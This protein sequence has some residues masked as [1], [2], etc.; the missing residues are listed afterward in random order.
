MGKAEQEI[1]ERL[2][3]IEGQI[4]GVR[5]MQE[6]GRYCIDVLDQISAVRAAL[7]AVALLILEGHVETCVHDAVEA[8]EGAEKGAE[9]TAAVRRLLKSA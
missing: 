7:S 1:L 9:L 5:R 2:R 6:D 4:A 8:G 3:R